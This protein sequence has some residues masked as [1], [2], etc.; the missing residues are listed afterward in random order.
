MKSWLHINEITCYKR[1]IG[2]HFIVSLNHNWVYADYHT[3]SRYRHGKWYNEIIVSISNDE[4]DQVKDEFTIMVSKLGKRYEY[5][6]VFLSRDKRE[7]GIL[8]LPR[9]TKSDDVRHNYIKEYSNTPTHKK[10][11]NNY[12]RRGRK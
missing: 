11:F 7:V 12:S 4:S 9:E 2:Y 3:C 6:D 10:R 8:L 5:C 1:D